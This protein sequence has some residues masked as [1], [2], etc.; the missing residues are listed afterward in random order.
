MKVLNI[1]YVFDYLKF[2]FKHK[3]M[4]NLEKREVCALFAENKVR[5][6]R[7]EQLWLEP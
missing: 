6:E 1:T 7:A 2:N 5:S 3:R 4:K